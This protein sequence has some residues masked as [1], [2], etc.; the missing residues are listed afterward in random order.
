MRGKSPPRAA[1]NK[2]PALPV[3]NHKAASAKTGAALYV[4]SSLRW[5]ALRTEVGIRC[6]LASV[7]SGQY[8]AGQIMSA[9]SMGDGHID[10]THQQSYCLSI[11]FVSGGIA[12]VTA[13]KD[14]SVT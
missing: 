14:D 3:E 2:R 6:D 1:P 7:S 5:V 4:V 10:N 12:A 8:H 13:I 11:D 9:S